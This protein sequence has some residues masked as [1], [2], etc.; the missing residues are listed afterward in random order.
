MGQDS[1]FSLKRQHIQNFFKG[2]EEKRFLKVVG[3]AEEG[4]K[5]LPAILLEVLDSNWHEDQELAEC[6]KNPLTR[7][8]FHYISMEKTMEGKPLNPVTNFHLGNGA[9]V[10]L[11]EVNFLAN[12]SERA[13]KDSLGFMVNYIYSYN[14][15]T[16]L[17]KA[18]RWLDKIE[19]KG[20]VGRWF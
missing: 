4:A 19:I 7:I 8:A 10:S 15:L 17:R 1:D 9:T 6:L 5:D 20:L 18:M 16:G 14:W 3:R 12:R 11:R 2:S 13:L